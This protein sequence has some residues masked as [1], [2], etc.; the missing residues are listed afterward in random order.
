[1]SGCKFIGRQEW[2][3]L[4]RH[5]RQL[6]DLHRAI[7]VR[8]RRARTPRSVNGGFQIAV[9]EKVEPLAV[10]APDGIHAVVAIDVIVC[11]APDST[12]NSLICSNELSADSDIG[13]PAAVRRPVQVGEVAVHR[14]RNALVL[15]VLDVVDPELLVFVV[16]SQPVAVGRGNPFP[17]QHLGVVG[18]LFRRGLR[19]WRQTSRTPSPRFWLRAPRCSCRR[20]GSAPR[21]NG[22]PIRRPPSRCVRSWR[23]CED[24]A[25]R[26]EH[27]AGSIGRDMHGGE[28]VERLLDPVLAH[29][30]EIGEKRNRNRFSC[31]L[32][33]S[34]SHRSEPEA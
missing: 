19:R 4:A 27:G 23:E 18:P 25:A 33:R 5:K 24:F 2:R 21:D 32:F 8:C 31:P 29:L 22:R 11:T 1:M 12:L 14:L 15:F 10:G 7:E 20:A 9:G 34:S 6:V 16:M 17:A 30:I 13:K 26:G 3:A 28:V